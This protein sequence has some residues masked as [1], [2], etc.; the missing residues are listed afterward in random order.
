MVRI[1][2]AQY[3]WAKMFEVEYA[4]CEFWQQEGKLSIR[5]L[6][7]LREAFGKVTLSEIA[8]REAR[9]RHEILAFLE[10]LEARLGF[11]DPL[12]RYLHYGL[13]SSDILDT[14]LALQVREATGLLLEGWKRIAGRLAQLAKKYSRTAMVGRTHGI[15][16]EPITFGGKLAG[17]FSEAQRNLVRLK[18]ARE[19]LSYGKLSGAVGTHVYH[20]PQ[21]EA[22][23]L[24]RLGLRPEP[25]STQVI[26]RDRHAEYFCALALSA[27][28]VER[29]AL[30]IRH[31]QRTEVREVEEPFGK[32]QK[33]SSAMPHKRNPVLCE[34]L[35]GL[36]RLVRGYLS[37]I[38][39]NCALWHE[40]DIS[41]SSVERVAF[42]DGVILLDFMLWRF[43]SILD[44]LRV[45]P[46]NMKRNL[47]ASRGLV[48]S[49]KILHA[50]LEKGIEREQAYLWV[51]KDAGKAWESGLSFQE[52]F[53][54]NPKARRIFGGREKVQRLFA[55][56]G[57]F[58]RTRSI[59]RR[60]GIR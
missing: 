24:R 22:R 26:P 57:Y 5:D 37:A 10:A 42:S 9:T 45:Y 29:F 8:R 14:A 7:R 59:L 17:W 41:H 34:N 36:A 35:A 50:L 16:A 19:I 1:F 52:I 12:K 11:G 33:G 28:A 3:R 60:A 53:E 49:Q 46:E 43:L 27:C 6:V 47:E 58:K 13:T 20:S 18:Q 56:D 44:G 32:G 54:R 23:V 4:A 51:Q 55:L 21:F 2:S 25:V 48:F 38:L 39:E 15:H 40:R 30:E 31:L